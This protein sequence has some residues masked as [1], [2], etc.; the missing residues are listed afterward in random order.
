MALIHCTKCGHYP[1]STSA[2]KCPRCGAPPYRASKLAP[3]AVAPMVPSQATDRSRSLSEQVPAYAQVAGIL[4]LALAVAGVFIPFV[5]VLFLTPIAIGLGTVALYGRYKVVGVTTL[6][7]VIVNFLISPTFWLNLYAGASDS[8]ASINRWLACFDI[9]GVAV[10]LY[11]SVRQPRRVERRTPSTQRRSLGPVATLSSA[12]AAVI[13]VAGI[14]YRFVLPPEPTP[15]PSTPARPVISPSAASS[16]SK[17][18]SHSGL[19]E[20]AKATSSPAAI[21]GTSA[22]ANQLYVLVGSEKGV[23]LYHVDNV[24][25]VAV[26]TAIGGSL[27]GLGSPAGMALDANGKLRISNGGYSQNSIVEYP[28]GARGN[29]LPTAIIA[30]PATELHD[31]GAIRTDPAGNIYVANGCGGS[32]NCIL[33]FAPTANGNAAPIAAFA[34]TESGFSGPKDLALDGLGG[35]YASNLWKSS[36]VQYKLGGDHLGTVAATISGPAT[37][38]DSPDGVA[39]DANGNPYITNSRSV[40]AYRSGSDG[41]AAPFL[42]IFGP[43]ANLQ[44]P[45]RIAIDNSGYI[46]IA[47]SSGLKLL[48]FRPGTNGDVAPVAVIDLPKVEFLKD[49]WDAS[50]K[51]IVLGPPMH[52]DKPLSGPETA[53]AGSRSGHTVTIQP[54]LLPVPNTQDEDDDPAGFVAASSDHVMSL[55]ILCGGWMKEAQFQPVVQWLHDQGFTITRALEPQP[56]RTYPSISFTAT[57]GQI[58]EAFHVTVL[59]KRNCYVTFQTFQMPAHFAQKGEN[60]VEGLEFSGLHQAGCR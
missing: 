44:Q 54:E 59:R 14:A 10:M 51:A 1:V 7:V 20:G 16:V 25:A 36:V 56:W 35:V 53:A 4:A 29:V 41:P 24:G 52:M 17:A 8:Q 55:S 3:T 49:A 18:P 47:N 31:P 30:G 39:V 15:A 26:V 57:V 40:T 42:T 34:G 58:E 32:H 33:E 48:K 60:Y 9:A 11:L 21:S 2:P 50:I 12:F 19:P 43:A 13:V 22:L 37:G 23:V 38:L 46:Y 45:H 6:V 5:G 28:P 27:T